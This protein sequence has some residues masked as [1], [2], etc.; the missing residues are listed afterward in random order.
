MST[1]TDTDKWLA[2]LAGHVEADD[3]DTQLASRARQ[4]YLRRIEADVAAPQDLAREKRLN[5]LLEAKG[6]FKRDAAKAPAAAV[7][8]GP[9]SRLL[10]WLLPA[11]SG[12]GGRYA[13]VATVAMAVVAAPAFLRS[14]T[15]EPGLDDGPVAKGGR[16]VQ[17]PAST[18][19][20]GSR[21]D[22]GV[23]VL[24]AG[25]PGAAAESLKAALSV[26]GVAATVDVQGTEAR[27]SA[28]VPADRLDAVA[29]VLAQA[30]V[31]PLQGSLLQLRFQA[32]P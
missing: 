24:V 23:V 29:P 2:V 10:G 4:L 30:G 27:L 18:P 19:V 13:L 8:P 31:P 11:E 15:T 5:N 14:P 26:I 16:G 20:P 9:I 7:Q 17:Q 28:S 25:S 21:A 3:A 22:A 1:T 6:A 32:L 12:H